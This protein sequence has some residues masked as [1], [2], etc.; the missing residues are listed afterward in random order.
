M[1][2][3]DPCTQEV[4]YE[5]A[6]RYWKRFLFLGCMSQGVLPCYSLT[7]SQYV[8]LACKNWWSKLTINDLR[9]SVSILK[10]SMEA[11][12]SKHEKGVEVGSSN[13]AKGKKGKDHV[14]GLNAE[15]QKSWDYAC[16]SLGIHLADRK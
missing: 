4:S 5:D 15:E 7:L 9:S 13:S 8:S 16:W 11:N 1:L 12:S 10:K 6:L 14:E 2:L 3:E